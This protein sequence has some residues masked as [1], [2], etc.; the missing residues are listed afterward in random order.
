MAS[1]TYRVK[2]ETTDVTDAVLAPFTWTNGR[3]TLAE[4]LCKTWGAVSL[5]KAKL[6]EIYGF[7]PLSVVTFGQEITLEIYDTAST[8]WTTAVTGKITDLA[9]DR[10]TITATFV[11]RAIWTITRLEEVTL[12]TGNYD[13]LTLKLADVVDAFITVTDSTTGGPYKV[14]WTIS[15][16]TNLGDW[17]ALMIA[18]VPSGMGY[19][20]DGL[21]LIDREAVPT[22]DLTL[23]A[24]AVYDNFSIAR[25]IGDIC[26]SVTITYHNNGTYTETNASS[27]TAIGK[28][29]QD[30]TSYLREA[31]DAETLARTFL[32]RFAPE[33][34]PVVAFTT[35]ADMIGKTGKW[36]AENMFPN[37]VI[38]ASA[39]TTIPF[40]AT[41]YVEQVTHRLGPNIWA[42]DLVA[43]DATY[44]N[45]PQTWGEVTATVK[46]SD[47][48]ATLTWG[49]MIY[50]EL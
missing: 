40:A 33:G 18:D 27:V 9:S 10:D 6:Q 21:I 36:V 49:D 45:L 5:Y 47:V 3:N 44:S 2:I 26:N 22:T 41:M 28:R 8:S 30:V 16:T 32:G 48:S 24:G 20:S 38:D 31:A 1:Y 39:I 17:A 37:L 42:L 11:D 15:E 35:S 46:W 14:H 23:T 34:W 50:Q 43:S 7:T 19:F 13:D 25:G 12:P 4:S 29:H